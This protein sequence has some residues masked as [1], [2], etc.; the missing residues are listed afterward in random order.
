MQERKVEAA[1]DL[2][3]RKRQPHS[4]RKALSGLVQVLGETERIQTANGRKSGWVE[5]S[6]LGA[7]K[8]QTMTEHSGGTQRGDKRHVDKLDNQHLMESCSQLMI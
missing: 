6:G 8:S 1:E 4:G 7:E 3:F 5:E 2:Q